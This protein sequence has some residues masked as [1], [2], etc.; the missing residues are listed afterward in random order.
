MFVKESTSGPE[1]LVRT[2]VIA[3]VTGLVWGL[4]AAYRV[5]WPTAA[6][7]VFSLMWALANFAVLA[8]ILRSA[9]DPAG[10]RK[11]T[12][13]GWTALK[14]IGLYPLGIGVLAAD[15]F[16]LPALAAGLVWPLVVV[17]LRA[18]GAMLSDRLKVSAQ[19]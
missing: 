3:G 6:G 11:R 15:F 16:P 19:A 10:P 4:L 17:V 18:L 13:A 5:D 2:A 9:T 7:F 8:R 1:F 12:V 14:L